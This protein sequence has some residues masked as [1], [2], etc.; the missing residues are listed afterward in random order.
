MWK[1]C[2]CSHQTERIMEMNELRNIGGYQ[3]S[4]PEW[5][6]SYAGVLSEWLWEGWRIVVETDGL[7]AV[8]HGKDK[9][10]FVSFEEAKKWVN[11]HLKVK[12]V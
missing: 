8:H 4:K 2:S 3:V 9:K 1:D 11:A 5:I 12:L 10:K 7:F 6:Y